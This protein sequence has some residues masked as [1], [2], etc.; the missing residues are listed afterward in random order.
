MKRLKIC[1]PLT[2]LAEI[3]CP[4][5]CVQIFVKIDQ[6]VCV[7]LPVLSQSHIHT[8]RTSLLSLRKRILLAHPIKNYSFTQSTLYSSHWCRHQVSNINL[9][10]LLWIVFK[11]EGWNTQTLIPPLFFH[12]LHLVIFINFLRLTKLWKNLTLPILIDE[13]KGQHWNGHF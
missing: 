6:S 11:R 12:Y 1:C 7:W 4:R 13:I 3:L 5:A 9:Q 8:N 2:N 10:E